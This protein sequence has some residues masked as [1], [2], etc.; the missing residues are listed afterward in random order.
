MKFVLAIWLCSW[1]ITIHSAEAL[2]DHVAGNLIMLNDNAG[3]CWYQ[4]EKI[5]YDPAAGTVLTSTIAN[6]LGYQGKPRE[7]D[8]DVTA[9]NPTTGQRLRVTMGKRN[10]YKSGDDHNIG[11]LWIRPDGK[12]LHVWTGHNEPTRNC[13]FRISE[14][15]HDATNWTPEATFNWVAIGNPDVGKEH[16]S[17]Y[18]NLHFLAAE[19]DGKGRLYDITRESQ[20]SPNIAYSD[21]FGATWHYGGKLTLTRTKSSY[22][23]G[24]MKFAS[25]GK[26]RID[27]ITTE[28]HPRNYNTSIYHGYIQGGK[29]YN[30]E[31]KVIDDNIFDEKAPAPEDFTPIFKAAEEDE[32]NDD[33]E[34]HRAWTIELERGP[35]GNLYAF[36]TT[37]YGTKVARKTPG[38]ADHRLFY[39]RFDGQK[40]HSTEIAKMGGP[41]WSHEEDY[42]GLGAI[43]PDNPNVVYISTTHDPRTDKKTPKHEIYR[44]QTADQGKTWQW[45]AVTANSTV[46]N[47]RPAIPRWDAKHTA[48]FWLRGKYD[49]QHSFDQT[50]VGL[51]DDP[52][53]TADTVAFVDATETNTTPAAGPWKIATGIGNGAGVY[54]ATAAAGTEPAIL[55]TKIGDLADGTY[56]VYAY[57]WSKKDEDWKL[58]AGF[59]ANDLLVFRRWSSQHA[60]A[61]QFTKDVKVAAPE[62]DLYRA[63]VGRKV[64]K[65]GAE[66]KVYIGEF[67]G[68]STVAYDG[69]GVAKVTTK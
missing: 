38:E 27:F 61:E 3:W 8:V 22:S 13:F 6:V 17:T 2:P 4:D 26:D 15:P 54:Q 33:Q 12:Y 66:I 37:R 64:V 67:Q 59:A 39:A 11:S 9:F 51:I 48:V 49:S 46:E 62:M 60:E 40:W 24:Y 42:V 25:N 16:T 63:Y 5:I 31:G 32:V 20:R 44:G 58:K 69:L 7:S 35:D 18:N 50:L 30:A 19:R 29:S 14:K 45:T 28:H 52:A 10:S 23:N 36:Y 53:V 43:H 56:D 65:G 47:L 55:T 68:E 1:A 57:F 34:Y 41:L 21:D